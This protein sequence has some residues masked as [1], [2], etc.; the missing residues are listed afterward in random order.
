MTTRSERSSRLTRWLI[1]TLP[2]LL[3]FNAPFAHAQ[4]AIAIADAPTTVIRGTDLY[5]ASVNQ[6]LAENDMIESGTSGILL[7]QDDAGNV[8]AFGPDTRILIEANARVSLL[9]GWLKIAHQCPASPCAAPVVETERGTVEIGDH[10]AAIVAIVG[11]PQPVTEAFSESGIQKLTVPGNGAS[12]PSGAVLAEGQF[13][14]IASDGPANLK[15]RP[16]PAFLDA[17]P[18]AFRDGL[19]HVATTAKPRDNLPAPLRP[20][21]FDDVAPWLTSALP[22]RNQPGTRFVDRFRP[23]LADVAFKQQVD[24]NALA[25]PEWQAAAPAPKPAPEIRVA[26]KST[27]AKTGSVAAKGGTAKGGIAEAQANGNGAAPAA[28]PIAASG[29]SG[30]WLTRLF[31][32]LHH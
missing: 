19:I 3:A 28:A 24:Q 2:F 27:T 11:A 16:S 25:L 9:R 13:A 15:P 23:R 26:Q 8:M 18:I 14:T 10:A 6:R 12:T 32:R 7:L 30:N 1:R 4:W 20:V 21:S 29:D 22:A 31:S 17:M 5:S